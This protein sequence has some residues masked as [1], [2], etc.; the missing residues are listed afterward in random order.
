MRQETD[1]PSR[2]LKEEMTINVAKQTMHTITNM[3]NSKLTPLGI[4]FVR[5]HKQHNLQLDHSQVA[6]K[7]PHH[8]EKQS[9]RVRVIMAIVT[10]V[11]RDRAGQHFPRKPTHKMK[12]CF[13][14]V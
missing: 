8:P 6:S 5:W 13:K 12:C 7:A 9:G 3:P 11:G 10:D 4:N 2:P 14:I 1:M